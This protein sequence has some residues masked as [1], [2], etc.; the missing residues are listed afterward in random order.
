M[1]L[2]V[3][4]KTEL[5]HNIVLIDMNYLQSTTLV[6]QISISMII[7]LRVTVRQHV[8]RGNIILSMITPVSQIV[9]LSQIFFVIIITS[10][11]QEKAVIAEIV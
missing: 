7:S 10:V 9:M 2:V 8:E 1:L 11:M 4:E 3:A 6:R 5:L